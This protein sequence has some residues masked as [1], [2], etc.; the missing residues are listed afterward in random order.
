[1][2][3]N[4]R[5]NVLLRLALFLSAVFFV[6]GCGG[7]GGGSSIT[8]GPVTPGIENS[9]IEG[10][11]SLNATSA[12]IRKSSGDVTSTSLSGIDCELYAFDD[13]GVEHL[14]A[15]TKTQSDG[16]YRFENISNLF[17]S[18][19][20]IVKAKASAGSMECVVPAIKSGTV[21]RAPTIN[22]KSGITAKIV[23]KAAAKS[24]Q[25]DINLGE[26]LAI[27]PQSVLEKIESRIDE[28]VDNFL[29]VQTARKEKIGSA[30]AKELLSYSYELQQ[31]MNEKIESGD[32]TA[33]EAWKLFAQKMNEK[34][35][36]MGISVQDLQTSNDLAQVAVF[37]PAIGGV[38][39]DNPG[40]PDLEKIE[41][42]KLKERKLNLLETLS[43]SVKLLTNDSSDFS[44]FYTLV[45][46]FSKMIDSA[47]RIDDLHLIFINAGNDSVRFTEY[48]NKALLKVNFTPELAAK[49]FLIERPLY[50][51]SSA[52]NS[53]VKVT[54]NTSSDSAVSESSSN[55]AVPAGTRVQEIAKN[56]ENAISEM[57]KNILEIAE[58]AKITL[59]PS[60]A[61]AIAYI[62]WA[63]TYENLNFPS[64]VVYPVDPIIPIEDTVYYGYGKVEKL[65]APVEKNGIT[66]YYALKSSLCYAMAVSAT[67]KNPETT[68]NSEI[69]AYLSEKDSF[70]VIKVESDSKEPLKG[71]LEMISQY[72]SVEIQG[73]YLEKPVYPDYTT[74]APSADSPGKNSTQPI[75]STSNSSSTSISTSD[76]DGNSGSGSTPGSEPLIYWKS[77]PVYIIVNHATILPPPAPPPQYYSEIPGK[78]VAAQADGINI[79][80]VYVFIAEDSNSPCNRS[81]LRSAWEFN[82]SES[83]GV[84]KYLDKNVLVSGT[85][86][87][88]ESPT[89]SESTLTEFLFEEI[90]LK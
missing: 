40:D 80:G 47:T 75:R 87:E 61:K 42:Q 64:P 60:Q 56:I 79:P 13:M 38:S 16:L 85:L 41:L 68:A 6:T 53:P 54:V 73:T 15:Q 7:G 17:K 11:V 8:N 24:P 32:L 35:I 31:T 26:L 9:S 36:R 65:A 37:D 77:E 3:R 66:Y 46:Y 86:V 49:V 14:I 74:A 69:I 81:I 45:S 25:N 50:G 67:G 39:T 5:K 33:E 44:E 72:E 63:N 28:V 58:S 2:V 83:G 71:N 27:V 43:A 21:V 48:L 52:G 30:Q 4:I 76:S 57:I 89:N 88:Y 29:A 1:M 82:R 20:L 78:V 12:S 19:N 10:Y 90:S 51:F 34:Q 22:P 23:R 18:I 59:D 62:I 84:K 70:E 55:S